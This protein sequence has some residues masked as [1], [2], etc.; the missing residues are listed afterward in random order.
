VYVDAQVRKARPFD[1]YNRRCVV[2]VPT[3]EDWDKRKELQKEGEDATIPDDALGEMKANIGF[4]NEDN[5][6]SHFNEMVFP[7]LNREEAQTLLE[8]YNKEAREAGFGKKHEQYQKE[9][10]DN[11]RARGSGHRGGRG[12]MRGGG[13][14]NRGFNGGGGM[15][16]GRGFGGGYGGGMGGGYGGGMGGGY[17]GG[18]AGFGNFRGG[19]GAGGYGGGNW[20]AYGYKF[21]GGQQGQGGP[22]RGGYGGQQGGYYPGN[23]NWGGWGQ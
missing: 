3:T 18:G 4:L 13:G 23:R 9:W 6:K 11:K 16:G 1:Q 20:G 5:M 21:S 12:F 22:A 2:I 17:G 7:E 8:Q 10:E 15:R 19:M 14:F